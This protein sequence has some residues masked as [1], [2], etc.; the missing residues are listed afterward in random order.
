MCQQ[1]ETV[2]LPF[3]L[4]N[5]SLA[6]TYFLVYA[7]EYNYFKAFLA[8]NNQKGFIGDLA[9]LKSKKGWGFF[10]EK[11]ELLGNKWYENAEPFVKN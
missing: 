2:C 6:H 1:R 11:G 5:E 7:Q 9:R 3:Y 8:G 10:N 4:G